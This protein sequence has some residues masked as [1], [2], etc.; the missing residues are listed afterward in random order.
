MNKVSQFLGHWGV[1]ALISAGLLLSGCKSGPSYADLPGVG[2][3]AQKGGGTTAHGSTATAGTTTAAVGTNAA[4]GTA[5]TGVLGNDLAPMDM[6]HPGDTLQ[7]TFADL[8][9]A[10]PPIVDRVKEDGT[11]TLLQNRTF[12][13]AGKTR[14]QLE[15]EIRTVYVPAY[16]TAMTVTV[17]PVTQ[18]Q[19]YYVGG[20]VKAPGQHVYLGR[21][22]VL[23]AI[24]AAGDFTDFADKKRIYLIRPNA[25]PILIN[26]KKART[27]PTLDLQVFPNDRIDVHRR[28]NPF[29]L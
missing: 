23:Q 8:P 6:I 25:Q 29:G 14:G 3:P 12:T 18:T 17:L 13:A 21:T 20:E 1:G 2:V 15:K 7:I 28:T 4:T 19:F 26:G 16:F 9:Y 5:S 22:T 27:D 10:Q 11:I 24:Q